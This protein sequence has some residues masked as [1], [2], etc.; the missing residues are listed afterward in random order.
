LATALHGDHLSV[1]QSLRLPSTINPK[2]Q[3][4]G[5]GCRLLNLSERRYR[6]QDFAAFLSRSTLRPPSHRTAF[7][8]PYVPSAELIAHVTQALIRRGGKVRG[9]WV[10][11]ACPF[12]ER[13]QH[14]DQHPSFGFNTRTG[15]GFCHVCGTLLLKDLCAALDLHPSNRVARNEV[16]HPA[17]NPVPNLIYTRLT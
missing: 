9:D 8:T 5:A 13:H 12:P 4:E 1:A 3:R 17:S 15:Y 11:G 10:N 7:T 16:M 14:R 2:P 6:L